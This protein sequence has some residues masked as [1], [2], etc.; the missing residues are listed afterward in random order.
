MSHCYQPFASNKSHAESPPRSNVP[1]CLDPSVSVSYPGLKHLTNFSASIRNRQSGS[2][3]RHNRSTWRIKSVICPTIAMLAFRAVRVGCYAQRDRKMD[4]VWETSVWS[5][6]DLHISECECDIELHIA[7]RRITCTSNSRQDEICAMLIIRTILKSPTTGVLHDHTALWSIFGEIPPSTVLVV[8]KPLGQDKTNHSPVLALQMPT[9]LD[10]YAKLEAWT[11]GAVARIFAKDRVQRPSVFQLATFALYMISRSTA[12]HN[13][14]KNERSKIRNPLKRIIKESMSSSLH[15]IGSHTATLSP[16]G[17]VYLSSFNHSLPSVIPQIFLTASS[18][19]LANTVVAPP[20]GVDAIRGL[21]PGH[22]SMLQKYTTSPSSHI[23]DILIDASQATQIKGMRRSMLFQYTLGCLAQLFDY[24]EYDILPFRTK[25]SHIYHS[26]I[27]GL[28][29]PLPADHETMPSLVQPIVKTLLEILTQGLKV[30]AKKAIGRTMFSIWKLEG[31]FS[32]AESCQKIETRVETEIENIERTLHHQDQPDLTRKPNNLVKEL[33]EVGAK[34]PTAEILG[35]RW[36][37]FG[38]TR[39]T[40]R[41]LYYCAGFRTFLLMMI[42]QLLSRIASLIPDNYFCSLADM[43]VGRVL[44]FVS[45][46]PNLTI[47]SSTITL[48]YEIGSLVNEGR[49]AASRSLEGL[50]GNKFLQ[51]FPVANL[52]LDAPDERNEDSWSILIDFFYELVYRHNGNSKRQLSQI[53]KFVIEIIDHDH[54]L[55]QK[56]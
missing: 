21:T 32:F 9:H 30:L 23:K 34:R 41:G 12:I 39:R 24:F 13:G 38:N 50:D 54:Q 26:Q 51:A 5:K 2:K 20:P 37:V 43:K 3:N 1:A 4:G 6:I 7:P 42:I 31:I 40:R 52:A 55:A 16:Y 25:A 27:R 10:V 11:V 33:R 45:H 56:H 36:E 35:S 8:S 22:W 49:Q 14:G 48:C 29:R 47:R 44:T 28:F 15:G 19:S 18:Q 17:N 46:I 53:S